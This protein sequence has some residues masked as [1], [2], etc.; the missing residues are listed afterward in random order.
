[1]ADQELNNNVKNENSLKQ[2]AFNFEYTTV[3]S[4]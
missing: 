1:M 3:Y 2:A 4:N